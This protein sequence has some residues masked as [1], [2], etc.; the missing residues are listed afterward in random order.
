VPHKTIFPLLAK[1][2]TR[3]E[4]L[5]GKFV[6][7]C[8]VVGSALFAIAAV[9]YFMLSS[10]G[11]QLNQ[12]FWQAVFLQVLQIFV[13]IALV[14]TLSTLMSH[15]ATIVSSFLLYNLLGSAGSTLEDLVY[16]QA[17]PQQFAWFYKGLLWVIPRFDLFNISKA[18]LHDAAPRPWT[19]TLPF[20]AYALCYSV[21]FLL[22]GGMVL[23]K[24][25]L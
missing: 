6:G 22:I 21:A 14:I 19:V 16:T 5:M 2:V 10:K 13:F 12:I 23:R 8:L 4:F 15:A 9:F 18:V 11:I 20:V 3:F 24:K 7:V 25:D 1:P 17:V